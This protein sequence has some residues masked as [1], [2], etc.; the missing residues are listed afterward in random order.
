MIVG[1]L[2]DLRRTRRQKLVAEAGSSTRVAGKHFPHGWRHSHAT[3]LVCREKV[4]HAVHRLM[5][6]SNIATASRYLHLVD[7]DLLAAIDRAFP[8]S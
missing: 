4:I 7:A 2:C 1:R 3:R 5:G 8:E 6:H